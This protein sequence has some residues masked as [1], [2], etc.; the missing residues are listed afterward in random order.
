[1]SEIILTGR[2]TQIRKPTCWLTQLK[3]SEIILTGCKTQ[4][5]LKLTIYL[6]ELIWQNVCCSMWHAHEHIIPCNGTYFCESWQNKLTVD[7]LVQLSFSRSGDL[8]IFEL[9][10][11]E[12]T[13]MVN[14]LL[15]KH[16][17]LLH[18]EKCSDTSTWQRYILQSNVKVCMQ[19]L[20]A[21]R[22]G[23]GIKSPVAPQHCGGSSTALQGEQWAQNLALKLCY[24]S[25]IPG[26]QLFTN[27][28]SFIKF[29]FTR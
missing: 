24:V 20:H 7:G 19:Q 26:T 23:H 27:N 5:L 14:F 16:W 6:A 8:R 3:M 2:K 29:I 13:F 22:F 18:P 10:L 17:D 12:V 1:M 25:T 21:G 11:I 28:S 4:I 15:L 9:T